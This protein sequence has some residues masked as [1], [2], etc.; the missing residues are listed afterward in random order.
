MIRQ[1]AKSPKFYHTMPIE[2]ERERETL[3]LQHK[4]R[5]GPNKAI[6]KTKRGRTSKL[7]LNNGT[8]L[9]QFAIYHY[10]QLLTSY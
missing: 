3:S 8:Y 2:R 7:W 9:W 6:S 4:E 1:R 5:A 10:R